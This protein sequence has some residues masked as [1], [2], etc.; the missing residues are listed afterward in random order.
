MW[1]LL[2]HVNVPETDISIGKNFIV[3][4]VLVSDGDSYVVAQSGVLETFSGRRN[5]SG[6][7]L[8]GF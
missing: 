2:C 8:T 1:F 5:I 7:S 4:S 3:I 6:Q